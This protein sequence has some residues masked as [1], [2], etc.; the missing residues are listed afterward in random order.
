[1]NSFPERLHQMK[2]GQKAKVSKLEGPDAVVKKF[3]EMGLM[4]EVHVEVIHEAP[5]T[6]DPFAIRVRGGLLG[7]S[8][9]DAKHVVVK[10]V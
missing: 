5:F 10:K 7:L 1:M 4:E 3:L 2:K 6:K 8:R 9:Q